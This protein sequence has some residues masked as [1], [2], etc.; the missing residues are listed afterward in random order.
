MDLTAWVDVAIGLTIIYLGA[1]LY[2]TIVNEYIAQ[3]LKL[4]SKQLKED[5]KKLIDS[6]ELTKQLAA[7]PALK[8]FFDETMRSASFIDTKVLAQQLVAGLNTAATTEVTMK[9]IATWISALNRDQKDKNGNPIP[10]DI[11]GPLLG[12]AASAGP[13]VEKFVSD[14]SVWFDTSLTMMGEKYKRDM[15]RNSFWI[16]LIIAICFNLDT[17][18]IVA[19][20]HKDKEMR[21]TIA[22]YATDLVNNVKED[23]FTKCEAMATDKREK[24]PGCNALKEL[25]EGLLS[26][27]QTFGK[28]PIG[29]PAG[30]PLTLPLTAPIGWLLTALAISLGAPFWFDLLNRL[31]NIRHGMKKPVVVPTDTKGTP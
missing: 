10:Y 18:N 3:G 6:P 28:L 17:I 31:V 23:V 14:L 20:L 19:H 29:M 9:G 11:K 25:R 30:W 16:G 7:N 12:L 22:A 4:R 2:V 27:N 15:Q 13:T 5:L 26:R 21:E 1:S 8:P 24:D